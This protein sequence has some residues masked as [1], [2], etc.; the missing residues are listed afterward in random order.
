MTSSTTWASN[1]A[2]INTNGVATKV[3]TL[4][5]FNDIPKPLAQWDFAQSAAPFYSSDGDLG[6]LQG[7]STPVRKITT[8]FGPGI[9]CD[10]SNYLTI[11]RNQVGRL[12]VAQGSGK[13]TVAA[14][15]NTSDSN[16]GYVAGCWGEVDADPGRSYGLF[17]DLPTYGGDDCVCFHVS[18]DGL[19]TPGY[20]YSRDYSTSRQKITR[21]VW[22]LYVGTYDGQ[23]AIS[24]L[25][26]VGESVKD[27]TDNKGNTYDKNPYQYAKGLNPNP[28]DFTVGANMLN[29]GMANHAKASF[30][31]IR[32]WDECLTP[33]QIYRMYK[34]ESPVL[35]S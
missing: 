13:V 11:P 14:W 18:I 17:F 35:Q 21:G 5:S 15:V 24:Y 4:E 33:Q 27:F 34:E 26:G 7:T 2:Y 22:Q 25:N 12:N 32:V 29:R 1:A 8:P 10:G 28:Y 23:Q 16:V 20:P 9:F 31:K 6:L 3:Q 30:A 19:P